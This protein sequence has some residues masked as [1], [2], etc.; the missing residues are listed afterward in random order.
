MSVS[1]HDG[2]K[3]VAVW[4]RRRLEDWEDDVRWNVDDAPAL[5]SHPKVDAPPKWEKDGMSYSKA[6]QKQ[7]WEDY[8]RVA[9]EDVT[10]EECGRKQAII[11][12]NIGGFQSSDFFRVYSRVLWSSDSSR[13]RSSGEW[14][15]LS[16]FSKVSVSMNR[17]WYDEVLK[18]GYVKILDASEIEACIHYMEL[19]LRIEA[20]RSYAD[21]KK[22]YKR[23][24]GAARPARSKATKVVVAS[25]EAE[26][27]AAEEVPPPSSK[28]R[29]ER[30]DV[31]QS[32]HNISKMRLHKESCITTRQLMI[33]G[34]WHDLIE[35]NAIDIDYYCLY[36]Y[37]C[38]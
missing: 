21:F 36:N 28:K 35:V 2:K 17:S 10:L 33:N 25:E 27:P 14:V 1:T 31:G 16:A 15:E 23:V 22:R 34:K 7:F 13:R 20:A 8:G 18:K 9:G 37:Y 11:C 26:A 5:V 4:S 6:W 12:R 19:D 38:L 24:Y 29:K 30:C 32:R 3:M